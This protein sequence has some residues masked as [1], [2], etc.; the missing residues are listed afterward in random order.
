M[1][2]SSLRPMFAPNESR[3][4]LIIYS[5]SAVVFLAVVILGR[6]QL[7]VDV[8]FDPHLF[9]LANA[10][11]NATVSVLLVSAFVAVRRKRFV[12][13]KKLMLA[14]ILLS[15]LFLVSYIAHHL[16][17]GET[18]FG[19]EGVVR[20]VYY[21]ILITHI[22]LAAVILPFILFTSYRSLT[23]DYARHKRLARYTF[24]V[25][26]YVAVTGVIVYLLISPYYLPYAP[27]VHP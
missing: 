24:P 11:I 25:W 18:T 17:A 13:H 2:D 14:A 21:I 8:G 12:A 15:V 4:R 3:A 26:L 7:Q 10:C 16:L 5:V 9:A 19:G 6:V 20:T 27:P 22:I 1:L 23:G